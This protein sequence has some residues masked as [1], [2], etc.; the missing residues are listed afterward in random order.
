[1][2]ILGGFG[3]PGKELVDLGDGAVWDFGDHPCQPSLGIDAIE[4]GGLDK[5]VNH[6]CGLA[7]LV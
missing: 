5:G 2:S 6:S 4:F 3:L 7:A 1:M